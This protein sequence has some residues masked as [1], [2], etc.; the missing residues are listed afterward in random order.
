M[1]QEREEAG[2]KAKVAK[3]ENEP[4]SGDSMPEKTE[5][6][7]TE[8]EDSGDDGGGGKEAKACTEI[9]VK[10]GEITMGD[11]MLPQTSENGG[12]LTEVERSMDMVVGRQRQKGGQWWEM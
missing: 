9:G 6:C 7:R 11:T 10:T 3:P 1:D 4:Y 8:P 5:N 2:C 12:G